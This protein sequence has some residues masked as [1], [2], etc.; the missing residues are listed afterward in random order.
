MPGVKLLIEKAAHKMCKHL[1][2]KFN[3]LGNT[4]FSNPSNV[5]ANLI[6]VTA[7]V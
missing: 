5:P 1:G 2:I 4:L 6:S 3:L 7:E